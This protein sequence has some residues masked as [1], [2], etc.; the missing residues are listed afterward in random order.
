M[1][2]LGV[3]VKLLHEA[4]GLEVTVEL[5][6]GSLYRGRLS[7]IEDSMNV[8]LRNVIG[9]APDGHVRALDHVLVRG[10]QVRL[11]VLPDNLRFA[12][13]VQEFGRD[14]PRGMGLGKGK[15]D[16]ATKQSVRQQQRL[17]VSRPVPKP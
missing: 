2:T 1:K 14:K 16:L 13:M 15:Q 12:P 10:N 8:Q 17:A 7:S 11:F 9:T 4:Q 6:N 5:T 3:P